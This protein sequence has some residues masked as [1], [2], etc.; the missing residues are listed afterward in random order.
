MIAFDAG[1]RV[2]GSEG[3]HP[4]VRA[5]PRGSGAREVSTPIC[6][7]VT[8]AN[9]AFFFPQQ[10]SIILS[11]TAKTFALAAAPGLLICPRSLADLPPARLSHRARAP[12]IRTPIYPYI[13]AREGAEGEIAHRSVAPSFVNFAGA[14][15]CPETT[16]ARTRAHR[17]RVRLINRCKTRTARTL[18]HYRRRYFFS[19]FSLILSFIH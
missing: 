5:R 6:H 2:R 1:E 12:R 10:T 14:L 15:T 3:A 9:L 8:A 17:H 11:R 18:L 16:P 7:F 19:D 4:K 13:C